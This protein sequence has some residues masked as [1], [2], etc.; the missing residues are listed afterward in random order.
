MKLTWFGGTTMRVHIGGKMLVIDAEDAPAG[1][2]QA[3][4]L[5]GA[6]VQ[7]RL[8]DSA[9][10]RVDGATWTPRRAGALIDETGIP[11]VQVHAV[12][13]AAVVVDAIGEQPLL[14]VSGEVER[15]GRWSG[16]AVAV[17]MGDPAG[18]PELAANVLERLGP[19]L[20]AIAAPE[21]AVDR[22]IVRV[23][24]RL[25]GTGLVALEAGLAVEV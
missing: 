12:G 9:L 24:D 25:D 14:L 8:D 5:S 10:G 18:L 6:D 17:V 15:L 13:P 4:L 3:E 1:I 2:D 22:A 16:N 19:K 20:I 7:L 11:E 23:R 21:D